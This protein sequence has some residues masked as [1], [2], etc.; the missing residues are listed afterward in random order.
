MLLFYLKAHWLVA[1]YTVVLSGGF[2]MRLRNHCQN[3]PALSFGW[4]LEFLQGRLCVSNQNQLEK[5]TVHGGGGGGV[6]SEW[7]RGR[8]SEERVEDEQTSAVCFESAGTEGLREG[9]LGM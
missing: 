8:L 7:K 1:L 4:R 6:K 5:D 2:R 9:T 3:I